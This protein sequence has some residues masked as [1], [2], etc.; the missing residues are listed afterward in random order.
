MS[1]I[2]DESH[3]FFDKRN[4]ANILNG[5]SLALIFL[6]G[7]SGFDID[8]SFFRTM[9]LSLIISAVLLFMQFRLSIRESI[10]QRI[11]FNLCFFLLMSILFRDLYKEELNHFFSF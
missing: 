5:G 9:T 1:T 2:E 10:K 7:M 11:F 4:I 8:G 6:M 3:G